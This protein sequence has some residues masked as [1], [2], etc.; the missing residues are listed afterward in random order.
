MAIQLL[1]LLQSGQKAEI[2]TK[3]KG[4]NTSNNNAK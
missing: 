2:N 1:P 3:N 4:Q